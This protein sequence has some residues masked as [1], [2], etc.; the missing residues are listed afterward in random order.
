MTKKTKDPNDPKDP[1]DPRRDPRKDAITE[2]VIQIINFHDKMRDQMREILR[3]L[4]GDLQLNSIYL[5]LPDYF[6]E[7]DATISAEYCIK[8][9]RIDEDTARKLIEEGIIEK[10]EAFDKTYYCIIPPW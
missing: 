9:S 4:I 3:G 10:R 8:T 5:A 1:K 2:I 7:Y 6:M